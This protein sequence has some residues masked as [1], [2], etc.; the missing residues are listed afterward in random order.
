MSPSQGSNPTANSSQS[1]SGTNNSPQKGSQGQSQSATPDPAALQAKLQEMQAALD[2]ETRNLQHLRSAY[3]Q[4]D[5]EVAELRRKT[6]RGSGYYPDDEAP[7]TSAAPAGSNIDPR[8]FGEMSLKV[9]REDWREHWGDIQEALN[10]P[11]TSNRFARYGQDGTYDWEAI[12]DS[13]YSEIR[14]RKLETRLA[15]LEAKQKQDTSASTQQQDLDRVRAAISGGGAHSGN[16]PLDINSLTDDQ[17][18]A[19]IESDP[20]DPISAH[21]KNT[22]LRD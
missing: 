19:L 9:N 15:E 8:K 11:L 1:P 14:S 10:D 17:L 3:N 4:R 22:T 13:A 5:Q 18:A 12:Y 6:E 20:N 2:K 16:E 7:Q 21:R